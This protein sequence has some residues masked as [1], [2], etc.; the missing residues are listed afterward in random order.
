MRKLDKKFIDI[1]IYL[2]GEDEKEASKMKSETFFGMLNN[3]IENFIKKIPV[4]PTSNE[5]IDLRRKRKERKFGLGQKVIK[6]E[7][8]AGIKLGVK[9][10]K[11]SGP[12]KSKRTNSTSNALSDIMSKTMMARRKQVG[13]NDVTTAAAGKFGDSDDDWSD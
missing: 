7:V 4:L 9:L 2:T 11:T 6:R 12:Q 1:I 5:G 8:M 13:G 10:K 3:F